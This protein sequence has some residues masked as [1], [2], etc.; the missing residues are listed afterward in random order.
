V[1]IRTLALEVCAA[2][3][4]FGTAQAQEAPGADFQKFLH[5]HMVC[6]GYTTTVAWGRLDTLYAAGPDDKL[7]RASVRLKKRLIGKPC[8]QSAVDMAE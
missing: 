1:K 8:M 7:L 4:L 6:F 2:V 3:A 5:K